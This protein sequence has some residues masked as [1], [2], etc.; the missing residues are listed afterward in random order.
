MLS[1]SAALAAPL[2]CVSLQALQD[3]FNQLM[4]I[5]IWAEV[6]KEMLAV[7][8]PAQALSRKAQALSS[9]S[10]RP[11][12]APAQLRRPLVTLPNSPSP[13]REQRPQPKLKL[14]RQEQQPSFANPW[15]FQARA[16]VPNAAE[17]AV[18]TQPLAWVS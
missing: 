6:R 12:P 10:K 13:A 18:G 11:A 14:K 7:S 4:I 2:I 15:A 1:R 16:A 17:Q 5:K 9:L 8:A 3:T